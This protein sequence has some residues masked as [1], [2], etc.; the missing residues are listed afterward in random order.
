M[1]RHWKAELSA[2]GLSAS[3]IHQAIACS[4]SSSILLSSAPPAQGSW[5]TTIR[6]SSLARRSSRQVATQRGAILASS[7]EGCPALIVIQ[8]LSGL[9]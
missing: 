4:V 3:R 1:V 2:A 7:W 8:P 9:G 6:A 5:S